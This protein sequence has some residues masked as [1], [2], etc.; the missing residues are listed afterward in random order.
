MTKNIRE[1]LFREQL[2]EDDIPAHKLDCT[3]TN[4]SEQSTFVGVMLFEKVNCETKT[5][6]RTVQSITKVWIQ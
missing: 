5:H 3:A 4:C 2:H 1:N 6:L